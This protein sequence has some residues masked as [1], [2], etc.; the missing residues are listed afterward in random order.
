MFLIEDARE[1]FPFLLEDRLSERGAHFQGGSIY[2]DNTVVDGRLVTGQN[3]WSTW[4]VAESMVSALGYTPVA[5]QRSIEEVS[6]ALLET[7]YRAGSDVAKR[8]RKNGPRVDRH[9]L[10]MHAVVAAMQGRLADAFAIQRLA[11]P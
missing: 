6:V 8:L 2:L 11:R 7:Y 5:R 4:S 9:L 3:P 1:L 10:L